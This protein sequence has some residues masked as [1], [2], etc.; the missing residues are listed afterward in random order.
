MDSLLDRAPCGY[1]VFSDAGIIRLVNA[2]MAELVGS[3]KEELI[4]RHFETLLNVGARIFY[5]T[6]FFPVLK[7]HGEA[8]EVYL[9]LRTRSGT[10]IPVLTNGVRRERAGEMESEC[11]FV[12]MQQ[13]SQ[14]EDEILRAKREAEAASAAKAKFLSMMSHELR[15]PLQAISGYCDLLLQE[16][17][18][19]ITAEQRSDLGA[20]QSAS[21][22]L[23]RLLQDI[24]D[25]ARLESGAAVIALADVSVETALKRAEALVNPKL[26]EAHL[27]YQRIAC[28]VDLQL[29]ANADRLQQVLLNLLT[30]AIKFT[31][32][33]GMISVECGGDEYTTRIAVRDTGCGIPPEHIEHIFDPFVQVD[34]HRIET[35]QRGVGLGLAISRELIQAMGGELSVESEAGVGSVFTIALPAAQER[36]GSAAAVPA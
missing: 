14:Y 27:R 29:R 8:E 28:S 36:T 34:R 24:L 13:R 3:T 22:E 23:V 17:S 18:G 19:P 30:N 7:L 26:T 15:T 25:F 2:T 10:E 5:H 1:V 20:V 9:T 11:V 35:R 6:H 32:A 4:G 31:P 16:V 12:R 21:G 33:D